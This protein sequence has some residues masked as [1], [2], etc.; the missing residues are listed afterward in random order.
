MKRILLIASHLGSGSSNLCYSLAQS[1][2]IQWVQDGLIF[3]DLSSTESILASNH[4]YSNIV[5]LYV[6][7]VFYNYQISHKIIYKACDFVYLIREP[8]SAIKVE[9]PKDATYALDY[10]I[11]RLR[12]LYEMAKETKNAM[13]LTWEDLVSGK[14]TQLISNKLNLPDEIKFNELKPTKQFLSLP[15][16]MLKKA[17]EAYELCLYRIKNKAQIVTC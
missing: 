6:N 14:G 4:K 3:D 1:K 17:E 12:R 10:Y 8:K 15:K 11:F 13:F 5:G 16:P 7:E 2:V 9:K